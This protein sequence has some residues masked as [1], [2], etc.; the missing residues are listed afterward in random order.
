MNGTAYWSDKAKSLTPYTPG[1]QLNKSVIK[2]NTNENA[3]SPSPQVAKAINEEINALRLYPSVDADTFKEAAA[4]FNNVRPENI[5]CG[6]GSDEVLAIAFAAL[7]NQNTK[8]KTF[9]V[10]Y[11]FY[12]VWAQLLDLELDTIALNGDFTVN[13]KKMKN[14]ECAV[15]A[16]PN[17]PTSIALD[18]SDLEL[19]IKTAG[20]AVIV[21]EAYFGFGA[22]SACALINKYP[23][24]LVVRTLSKSHA[25]AGLRAGYAIGNSDLIAALYAVKNSFNSYPV[26]R[27]AAIGATAALKD[28]EYYQKISEQIIKT[29]ED[30]CSDLKKM[31]LVTLKSSAN[32]IFVKSPDAEGVFNK[33]RE[34][35]IL[36]RYFADARTKDYL[37]VTIGTPQQMWVFLDTLR[38]IL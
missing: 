7:F 31:G 9:D 8:I 38:K 15:I 23:N 34:N 20:G 25:L 11:S 18:I 17:A 1:E 30:I 3:Y 37:R 14:A 6:N 16:N 33:L 5:F 32:F 24:L 29:R 10:T 35:N 36:V 2:L 28:K 27:L 4:E 26:D 12:K 19:I 21:D 22:K 13:V